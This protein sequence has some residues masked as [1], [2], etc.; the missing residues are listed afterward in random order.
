MDFCWESLRNIATIRMGCVGSSDY[1]QRID[2]EVSLENSPPR[3]FLSELNT[4]LFPSSPDFFQNS[5]ITLSSVYLNIRISHKAE[6]CTIVCIFTV[7]SISNF[8]IV[9]PVTHG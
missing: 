1:S 3:C 9:I 8:V 4:L 6:V 7:N 5:F 2:R